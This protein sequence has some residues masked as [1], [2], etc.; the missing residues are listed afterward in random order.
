MIRFEI[1]NWKLASMGIL[2][3]FI[4]ELTDWLVFSFLFGVFFGC[5]FQNWKVDKAERERDEKDNNNTRR[6]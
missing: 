4:G 2:C 6:D 5:I 1:A 3:F